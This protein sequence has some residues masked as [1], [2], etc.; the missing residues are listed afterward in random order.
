MAKEEG[1]GVEGC[2]IERLRNARF[3]VELKEGHRVRAYVAG[4]VR[5]LARKIMEGDY[6]GVLL[7][8]YDLDQGRIVYLLRSKDQ[9]INQNTNRS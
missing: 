4:K 3:T 8:P 9:H 5:W 1:I 2:V 6:V 7:S